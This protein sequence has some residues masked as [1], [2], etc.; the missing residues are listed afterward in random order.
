MKRCAEAIFANAR[1]VV[2]FRVRSGITPER[3]LTFDYFFVRRSARVAPRKSVRGG[4]AVT[5]ASMVE[6][7]QIANQGAE[8]ASIATTC[9]IITLIGLAFG[10]VLLRVE[11]SVVNGE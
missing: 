3:R 4:A 8:I 2:V 5:K 6:V 1:G 10:F 7:A 9:F 11:D